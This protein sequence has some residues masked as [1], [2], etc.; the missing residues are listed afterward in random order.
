LTTES[1]MAEKVVAKVGQKY[2]EKSKKKYI[3]TWM[4]LLG[5]YFVNLRENLRVPLW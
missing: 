2:K 1:A 4:G 3:L 5:K